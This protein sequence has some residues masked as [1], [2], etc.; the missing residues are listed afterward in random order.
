[1]CYPA[2]AEFRV[3]LDQ[4][5]TESLVQLENDIVEKYES[6]MIQAG[7]KQKQLRQQVRDRLSAVDVGLD[8][9]A[10]QHGTSL[11]II[12]IRTSLQQLE[13]LREHYNSGVLKDVLEA[14]FVL[15]SGRDVRISS[16]E[17][18]EEQFEKC[19]RQLI[20]MY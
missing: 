7:D 18:K 17:W 19:R 6:L 14:V 4:P 5:P 11:R 20:C 10:I 15:L 3:V 2:A 12:I 13:Q 9:V 1:M 16:A 8:Q